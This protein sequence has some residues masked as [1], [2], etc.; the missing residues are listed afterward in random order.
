[1][2]ID[3][4]SRLEMKRLIARWPALASLSED[5]LYLFNMVGTGEKLI[6]FS[7][8]ASFLADR[9]CRN[10]DAFIPIERKHVDELRGSGLI[11][12]LSQFGY[13]VKAGCRDLVGSFGEN[14][15]VYLCTQ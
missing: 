12:P 9:D 13:G 3:E 5:A 8:S 1:M 2:T 15:D 4:K 7:P 11:S 10:R 14:Y 6:L